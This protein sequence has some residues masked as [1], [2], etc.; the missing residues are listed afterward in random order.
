M[1]MKR[2]NVAPEKIAMLK[3]NY[4]ELLLRSLEEDKERASIFFRPKIRTI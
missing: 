1:A 3:A 2:P 4:E